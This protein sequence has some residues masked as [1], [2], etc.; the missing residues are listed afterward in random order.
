MLT[1]QSIKLKT[2]E[3]KTMCR[4]DGRSTE[5]GVRKAK[6]Q[7]PLKKMMAD[8]GPWGTIAMGLGLH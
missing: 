7:F 2:L 3:R 6:F 8:G 5:R 1:L 4:C